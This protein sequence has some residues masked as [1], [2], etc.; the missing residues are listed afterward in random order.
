MFVKSPVKNEDQFCA[1]AKEYNVLI[2][3]GWSFACP[4]YV[5]IAYCVS[6][7]TIINALPKF[8]QIAEYYG[9]KK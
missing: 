8:A 2:V 4:G 1:K 5:R 7:E 9:L 3:P 6:H